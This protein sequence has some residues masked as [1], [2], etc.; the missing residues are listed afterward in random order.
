MRFV[1]HVSLLALA[2]AVLVSVGCSTKRAS[3]LSSALQQI[4]EGKPLH[5]SEEVWKDVGA[6]YTQ[7]EFTSAW[8]DDGHPAEH[9]GDALRVLND[10]VRHAL[11]PDEYGKDAIIDLHAVLNAIDEEASRRE[12][13]LA[14]FDAHVT[15][16]LLAL[17]RDV[18]LGRLDPSSIV[19]TW[20]AQR[21]PPDLPGTLTR[22][23]KNHNLATWLDNVRPPHREY[24]ALQKAY[25]DLLAQHERGGW[26]QVPAGTYRRGMSHPAVVVLRQRLAASGILTGDAATSNAPTFD[27]DVVRAVHAFQELHGIK[28]TGVVDQ[29]TLS[30]MNVP[31][32]ER[33]EQVALNLERWRWMPNELGERHLLV[34]IPYF[35][36]LAREHGHTVMD[37]RVVVGKPGDETPVFSD[38]METVVFSPYWYIPDSIKE[39]E[40]A[41]AV[42]ADPDYLARNNIEVLRGTR[43]VDVSRIDWQR[44]EEL[45]D[46]AFRQRPGASNALG[47][48]KFL[49]PNRFDVYLHDTPADS[50]FERR[51]RAFSHGCVRVEEPEKLVQY[52]LRGH[53]G[54]DAPRIRRAMYAGTEQ[55]V[56]LA[57]K[58]PVHLTYFT[59]WVDENGGLH[60]KGDIYGYDQKQARALRTLDD[61][62]PRFARKARLTPP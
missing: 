18:A 4:V 39:Q 5:Q 43:P 51:G 27:A 28:A 44:P 52:V 59:A 50:L 34:N 24:V 2:L 21:E 9:A 45:R 16:S 41:P 46:L 62:P 42:V 40:T 35:H 61:R 14:E 23:I 7:R 1:L 19:S 55:Q 13:L 12:E 32:D 38:E 56:P 31:V 29:I 60:F 20:K 53:T 6:F 25:A 54:W 37:V 11:V 58:I 57:Q 22:A 26:P 30:A 36:L 33:V 3:G 10:A 49:F 47:H 8:T 17:G 15:A 48:V